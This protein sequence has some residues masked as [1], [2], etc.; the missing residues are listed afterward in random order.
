[1][2][3]N[4]FGGTLNLALLWMTW[5]EVLTILVVSDMALCA[6]GCSSVAG[7]RYVQLQKQVEQLQEELYRSET[8]VLTILWWPQFVLVLSFTL[9]KSGR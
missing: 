8:G 2:T 4:V 9:T 7:R 1:M 6:G 3:Y 5:Y